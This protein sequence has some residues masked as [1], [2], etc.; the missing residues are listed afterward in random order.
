LHLGRE[1]GVPIDEALVNVGELFDDVGSGM[2][3][4]WEGDN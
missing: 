2:G 3:I 4:G 1:N